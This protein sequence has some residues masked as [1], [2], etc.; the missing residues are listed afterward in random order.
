MTATVARL[1]GLLLVSLV[2]V[3]P[4]ASLT[5]ASPRIGAAVQAGVADVRVLG[6]TREGRRLFAYR[7]GQRSAR[8]TA[9]VLSTMHGDERD[10]VDVITNLR[11]GARVRGIDLWLVPVYNRDGYAAHTRANSRAST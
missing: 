11:D 4:Q 6:T 9:V 3:A 2:A 7:V 10:T 8:R 1:V 5:A